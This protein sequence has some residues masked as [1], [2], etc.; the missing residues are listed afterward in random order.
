MACNGKCH[1]ADQLKKA[2]TQEEEGKAPTSTRKSS[3]TVYYTDSLDELR[4]ALRT[5]SQLQAFA[6]YGS[7]YSYLFVEGI[8]HPPQFVLSIFLNCYTIIEPR[9][10]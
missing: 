2:D 9:V 8:F 7:T 10:L 6:T 3:E 5:K 1:L 4:I